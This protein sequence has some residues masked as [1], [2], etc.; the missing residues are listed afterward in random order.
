MSISHSKEVKKMK[1]RVLVGILLLCLLLVA[2]SRAS[3]PAYI[4]KPANFGDGIWH[5]MTAGW[6]LLWDTFFKVQDP[7]LYAANNV[8]YWYNAGFFCIAP[9]IALLAMGIPYAILRQSLEQ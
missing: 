8:G 9:L 6:I 1:V 5:G 2:C 3:N 7:T 4:D